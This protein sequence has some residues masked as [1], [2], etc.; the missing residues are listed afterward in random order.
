[1]IDAKHELKTGA[2]RVESPCAKQEPVGV[3]RAALKNRDG[4]ERAKREFCVELT[5]S[6]SERTV[7]NDAHRAFIVVR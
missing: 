1:M 5:Q 7:K 6:F 2:F 4:R 3:D